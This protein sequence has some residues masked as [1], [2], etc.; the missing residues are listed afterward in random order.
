MIQCI[1]FFVIANKISIDWIQ[2]L[3]AYY[4]NIRTSTLYEQSASN[5]FFLH[6]QKADAQNLSSRHVAQQFRI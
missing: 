5:E 2:I 3:Q 6:I 1:T 4:Y